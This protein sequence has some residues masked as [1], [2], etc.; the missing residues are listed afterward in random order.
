MQRWYDGMLDPS[1]YQVEQKNHP[2]THQIV[3]NNELLFEATEVWELFVT[4]QLM[5]DKGG[6]HVPASKEYQW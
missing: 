3:R 2:Q 4:Q 1:R 5:T 6:P